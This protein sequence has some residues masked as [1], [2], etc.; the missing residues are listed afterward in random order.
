MVFI[1]LIYV[2]SAFP[3]AIVMLVA[4]TA[5]SEVTARTRLIVLV[6]CIPLLFTPL[7]VPVSQGGVFMAAPAAFTVMIISDG[8]SGIAYLLTVPWNRWAPVVVASIA[9]LVV[10]IARALTIVGGGREA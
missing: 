3:S 1:L 10:L 2:L 6:V 4:A 8:R 7:L 9:C 5:L